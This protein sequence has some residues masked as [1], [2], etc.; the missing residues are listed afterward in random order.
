MALKPCRECKKKVSTEAVT[1]PSCGVP[2]PT[3]K[4]PKAKPWSDESTKKQTNIVKSKSNFGYVR[5][6]KPHCSDQYKLKEIPKKLVNKQV[7]DLCGNIMVKVSERHIAQLDTLRK[8]L[9]P[10]KI[11]STNHSNKTTKSQTFSSEKQQ[12]LIEKIWWGNES[13]AT[14]F[15]MYCILTVGVVS[16]IAGLI[17]EIVG[18]IIFILPGLVIIW[19]NTGLWRCSEKF[20]SSKLKRNQS[21]G[22]ATAAKVYVVFNY[23]TTISQLSL[24]L[25]TMQPL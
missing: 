10:H 3:K 16:F 17:F 9:E 24:K 20:K 15:W 21:Y 8:Y 18:A 2:N 22:W 12:N 19:T 11:K 6:E 23:L 1:C 7:C 5:C 4:K 14:I 13:L 25:Q